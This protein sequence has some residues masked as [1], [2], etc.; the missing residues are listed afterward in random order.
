MLDVKLQR[1]T[2]EIIG[3]D[4]TE[5]DSAL[6]GEVMGVISKF[7][8]NGTLASSMATRAVIDAFRTELK[9]RSTIVVGAIRRV[10]GDLGTVVDA[11]LEQDLKLLATAVIEAEAD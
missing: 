4:I 3:R 9:M 6:N 8:R 11:E 2:K 7:S 1:L 10:C 5:R